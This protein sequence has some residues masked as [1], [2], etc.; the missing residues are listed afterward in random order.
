EA[1]APALVVV[2]VLLMGQVR[3][4]DFRDLSIGIPAFLTI[5]LMPFTYSITNGVGAGFISWVVIRALTGK[6]RSIHP[7]LWVV[8]AA[9]AIYFAIDPLKTLFGIS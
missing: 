1:A 5:V 3:H 2:G 9:F 4:I 8:S 6:A 7:L